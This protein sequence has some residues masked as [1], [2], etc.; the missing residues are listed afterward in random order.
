MPFTAT[1]YKVCQCYFTLESA[2]AWVLAFLKTLVAQSVPVQD[3]TEL[4][5]FSVW[6]VRTLL[7]IFG[8]TCSQHAF[9]P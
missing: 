7:S 8:T 4:G 2:I 1:F 5:G 9:G 3:S 6:T